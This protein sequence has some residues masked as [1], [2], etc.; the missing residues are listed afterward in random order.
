MYNIRYLYL[1]EKTIVNMEKNVIKTKGKF[2][3]RE[4]LQKKN[5]KIDF[6]ES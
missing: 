3:N 4:N 2:K 6:V 1:H 5:K